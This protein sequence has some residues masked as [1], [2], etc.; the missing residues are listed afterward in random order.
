MLVDLKSEIQREREI[1]QKMGVDLINANV[2]EDTIDTLVKMIALNSGRITFDKEHFDFH[3]D[4]A[5]DQKLK[6]FADK[7]IVIL[8]KKIEN[9]A[10]D[11]LIV[12]GKMASTDKSKIL[13]R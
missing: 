7:I 6:E 13:V 8:D 10:K 3:E 5:T 2:G 12:E 4:V 11:Q 9:L 1:Y